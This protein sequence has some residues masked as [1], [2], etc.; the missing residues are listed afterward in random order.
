MT[1]TTATKKQK[2][3][4]QRYV[5]I[6]EWLPKYDRKF[7]TVDLI[8]GL[9]VWALMV[10]QALGYAGV[11]GVPTQYGLY[12]AFAGLLMYA[13]FGTSRQVVTGPSSTVAAVTGAAV[14]SVATAGSDEAIALAAAM[15]LFAGIF[16]LILGFFRMGWVS[17]FLAASVLSGF[18]GGIAIDVA[19]GQLDNLLGIVVEDGNSWQELL[20]SIQA[21]PTLNVTAAVIGITSLAILFALKKW[22]PKIPGALVVVVL[23]I[24]AVV[25]FNLQEVIDIVGEV[26]TGLP[27][28]GLPEI[29]LDQL[30]IVIL[31]AIGV[32][33]V[34]FSE[35][36]A[37][38]RLYASK[39]HYDISTD[40]EMVAQGFAN[41]TSG[42]ISG[43]GVNGSLSKSGAN[44]SAGGKTEMASLF[45]A[46]LILLTMLFL[47]ALFTDLPQAVLGAI[48]IAAV[49]PLIEW[50][51]YKRLYRIQRAEFWLAIAAMLGV[52]TFGTLQGV[53]IGVGLSLLLLIARASR[54]YIPVLAKKPGHEV[55]HHLKDYPDYEIDPDLVVVRFE[56][57]LYFATASALRERIREL[58]V[59]A[60]P[61]V[62]DV[63]I[64]MVA[65]SFTDIEGADMIRT[66]TEEMGRDGIQVHLAQ[67]HKSVLTF[68]KEDGVDKVLGPENVHEDVF[69][70]VEA[71]RAGK[72]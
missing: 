9:S 57:D 52:L 30:P 16:Y 4:L 17:N 58:V 2:S 68:L 27:P 6:L 53:I 49:I 15:A 41:A 50:G 18:I 8:A 26:P 37:A 65:V 10:P 25:I 63:V 14:L 12:A 43:F 1:T 20:W 46:F 5:P 39:Y 11:A 54:P 33:L 19:I 21:L 55:Y 62:K 24:L 31:G 44:D 69:A 32:V 3:A 61:A 59:G 40:Q 28:I 23:G 48:V 42:L 29:S 66:V 36:L 35:S 7:L 64:D 38:G 34:G 22:A 56:G 60:D 72:D 45:Q 13:I 70:A 67:V 71:I 51:E 47:A